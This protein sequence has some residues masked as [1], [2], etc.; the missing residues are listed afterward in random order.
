M[1]VW[2]F[3]GE[4]ELLRE[5]GEGPPGPRREPTERRWVQGGHGLC[6]STETK[7]AADGLRLAWE[8]PRVPGMILEL[9][10]TQDPLDILRQGS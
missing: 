8:G 9:V 10:C 1:L 6:V 3:K 2:V 7:D 4:Q 5:G